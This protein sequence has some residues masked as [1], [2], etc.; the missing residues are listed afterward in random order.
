MIPVK[1]PIL[2][3]ELIDDS[4]VGYLLILMEENGT[5]ESGVRAG[6]NAVVSALEN[7]LNQLIPTLGISKQKPSETDIEELK[8]DIRTAVKASILLEVLD[9]LEIILT[10]TDLLFQDKEL[11]NAHDY[12]SYSATGSPIIRNRFIHKI[13]NPKFPNQEILVGDWEI[14][15]RVT[16][17]PYSLMKWLELHKDE[18]KDEGLDATQG[19][20]SIMS[21]KSVSTIKELIESS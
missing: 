20:R 3:V 6:Y 5:L 15:G 7:G 13:K 16:G 19:I 1:P 14:T 9:P 11:G 10:P 17:I 18:L 21:S 12:E 8:K 2:G 4:I